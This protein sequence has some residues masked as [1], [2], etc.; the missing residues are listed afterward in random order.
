MNNIHVF[1]CPSTVIAQLL[2]KKKRT[3]LLNIIL[4]NIK[5]PA[6]TDKLIIIGRYKI[7]QSFVKKIQKTLQIKTNHFR[8]QQKIIYF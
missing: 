4:S 8:H 2:A 6:N 7:L 1:L 3:L 5:T